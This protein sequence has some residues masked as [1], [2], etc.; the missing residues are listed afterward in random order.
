VKIC[1]SSSLQLKKFHA[2]GMKIG[3]IYMYSCAAG[4]YTLH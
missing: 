3:H 4:D 1:G 2:A